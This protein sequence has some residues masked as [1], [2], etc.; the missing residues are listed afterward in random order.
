VSVALAVLGVFVGLGL[1]P[2]T[3]KGQYLL[4]AASA[5]AGITMLA[6]G[7]GTWFLLVE[8]GMPLEIG[9]AP[10]A[11]AL[12]LL[13][14]ASSAG[15]AEVIDDAAHRVAVEIAALDDVLPIVVG[16]VLVAA[17]AS[18]AALDALKLTLVT[19]GIGMLIAAA[20]SLLFERA[21]SD[22]ERLVFVLG[23][24]V[25][26]GGATAYLSLSPLLAGLVAG[27]FW[28]LL[29]GTADAILRD[30]LGKIQHPLVVILVVLAGASIELT[31]GLAWL[32]LPYVL[33]RLTGKLAGG[34]VASAMVGR[35]V[36][37][38]LGS[39][40]VSPGVLGIAFAL[41]LQ[42]VVPRAAGT[43]LVSVA[44]LGSLA[45]E[46]LVVVIAARHGEGPAAVGEN[47]R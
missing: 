3:G 1:H 29:P 39:Y 17:M 7:L 24:I 31:R 43:L 4:A 27:A 10:F 26:L 9:A 16:G 32:I 12:A 45:S 38:R 41:G 28:A 36:S 23:T 25:L 2:A 8:W 14:S 35:L 34:R 44:A 15:A 13:G 37:P 21:R 40:L 19:A 42:Q 30:D 18:A 6:T 22:S 33:F 5:E 47:D 11:L 20:G 46:A